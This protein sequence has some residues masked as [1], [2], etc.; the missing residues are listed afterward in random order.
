M[1]GGEQKTLP[2]DAAH[3]EIA[4]PDT[5]DHKHA[6]GELLHGADTLPD[7]REAQQYSAAFKGG[8]SHGDS[9]YHGQEP[10]DDP[11]EHHD[12]ACKEDNVATSHADH[13][14]DHTDRENALV[15]HNS[16]FGAFLVRLYLKNTR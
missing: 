10:Q 15:A 9:K 2:T 13:A 3:A 11:P 7:R 12:W 4:A 14:D 6:G 5:T 16:D 1:L 8:F